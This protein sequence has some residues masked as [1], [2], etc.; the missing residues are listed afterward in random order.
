LGGGCTGGAE[1][2]LLAKVAGL[3]EVA[4]AAAAGWEEV[5]LVAVVAG[6]EEVAQAAVLAGWE[7]VAL[8]AAAAAW[9]KVARAV[10]DF[11]LVLLLPRMEATVVPK[12]CSSNQ[13]NRYQVYNQHRVVY[14]VSCDTIMPFCQ[15]G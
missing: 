6:L 5:S 11:D 4:L 1:V 7:E 15:T 9:E 2:A 3:E 14:K 13:F 10:K 8:A 12:F